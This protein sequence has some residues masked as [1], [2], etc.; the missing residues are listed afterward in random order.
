MA[1]SPQ[2]ILE[3]FHNLKKKYYTLWVSRPHLLIPCLPLSIKQPLIHILSLE[4]PVLDFHV[5]GIIHVGFCGWILSM[6]IMLLIF[7]KVVA[8]VSTFYG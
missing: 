7:I 3:H 8:C 4:S 1:P 6:S 2:S 5:K